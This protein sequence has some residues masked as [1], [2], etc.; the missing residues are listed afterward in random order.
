MSDI[1]VII[2]P[3]VINTVVVGIQG[4]TGPKG[5]TEFATEDLMNATEG[6][7]GEVAYCLNVVDV[8]WK[9]SVAEGV[10]VQAY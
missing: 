6:T 1:T 9:W 3:E 10:W 5:I 2:T 4:P 8:H 7:P